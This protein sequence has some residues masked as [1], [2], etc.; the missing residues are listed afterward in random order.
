MTA[1]G[2]SG[3]VPSM[4]TCRLAGWLGDMGYIRVE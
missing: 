1:A 3:Q 4:L 2:V